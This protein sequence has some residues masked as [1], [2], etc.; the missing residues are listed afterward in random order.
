[1]T[2]DLREI[3]PELVLVDPDLAAVA[4]RHLPEP[5]SFEQPSAEPAALADEG[6][7]V[8]AT[9]RTDVRRRVVRQPFLLLAAAS[10]ALNALFIGHAQS[11]V[12]RPSLAAAGPPEPLSGEAPNVRLGG[13][14]LSHGSNVWSAS[15]PASG[16]PLRE[17]LSMRP[18]LG[19]RVAV[20]GDTS[21]AD[22]PRP[23]AEGPSGGHERRHVAPAARRHTSSTPPKRKRHEAR[24]AV[25]RKQSS[26][27]RAAPRARSGAQGTAQQTI[28]WTQVPGATYYNLVLWREGER[29]LDL[30]PTS[31]RARLP[32]SGSAGR[33]D[34]GL[35]PGRYL[36]F[37][38]PGFGAKASQHYGALAGSGQLVIEQKGE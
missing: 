16:P 15:S 27:L 12:D 2:L 28:R 25:P 33:A 22:T 30:W 34:R 19:R 32:R 38:Y 6:A 35:S 23:H 36:W 4:R 37:V 1:M 13:V 8:Q 7:L 31:A 9:R 18:A 14:V 20:L 17:R 24:R 5:G 26:G 29:V 11:S 3:S 21:A 10:L